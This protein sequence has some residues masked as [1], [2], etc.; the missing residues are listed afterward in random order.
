MPVSERDW[1][2]DFGH[3]NGNY[4]NRCAVCDAAFNGHKRRPVCRSC[5]ETARLAFEALTPEEQEVHRRLQRDL[6]ASILPP[7]SHTTTDP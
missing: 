2:E 6:I 1:P 3:E 5:S 7:P 4:G